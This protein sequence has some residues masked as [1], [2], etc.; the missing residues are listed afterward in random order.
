M[1]WSGTGTTEPLPIAPR[2]T[3]VSHLTLLCAVPL[4]LLKRLIATKVPGDNEDCS[5]LLT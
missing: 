1:G 3:Q 4:V 2:G 5:I